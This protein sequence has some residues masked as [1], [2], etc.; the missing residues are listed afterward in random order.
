MTITLLILSTLLII[1]STSVDIETCQSDD[2]SDY[3]CIQRCLE[4]GY[5]Q[6]WCED[7]TYTEDF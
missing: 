6:A 1:P 5:D 7:F 3:C 2:M 4:D